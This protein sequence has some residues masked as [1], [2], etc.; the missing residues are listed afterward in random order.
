MLK[1]RMSLGKT[2]SNTVKTCVICK[3]LN[4]SRFERSIY[5]QHC[6]ACVSSTEHTLLQSVSNDSRDMNVAAFWD[7]VSCNL[8]N[9]DRRFRAT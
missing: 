8:V 2:T 7:A 4:I 6:I 1:L 5:E 3:I 9:A